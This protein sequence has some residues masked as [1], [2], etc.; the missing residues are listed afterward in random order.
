VPG[1]LEGVVVLDMSVAVTGP[2][3]AWLLGGMGARVIKL[4]GPQGDQSRVSTKSTSGM[5]PLFAMYNGGKESM[6]L[7]LKSERG[8]DVF[9]ELIPKVDVLLENLVGDTMADWGLDYDSL[10]KINPRLVYASISGF[11]RDSKYAKAPALDM[12]MQAMSGMMAATGFPEWPPTLG[13]VLFVD[14]LVSPHVAAGIVAA[15]YQRERTGHG[16]RLDV[17]M[18]DVA[19]C[20][21]FNLYNIFYNTGRVPQ[22]SGN[23]LVGY[24]PGNLYEASDG[25]VYIASN[26]DKQAYGAF[27]TIGREDL[28]TTEGF[29]TRGERWSNREEVDRIVEAWTRQRAKREVFDLM[30]ANDV[31]CGI[32]MDIEEVLNDDDLNARGVFVGIEQPGVGPLK[33]PRPPMIFGGE[34]ATVRPGRFLGEDNASLYRELLGYD[35]DAL[36]A[37]YEAGAA[38]P[39]APVEGEEARAG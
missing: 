39:P 13:G 16:Q 19:V 8:R 29:R 30:M 34:P 35:D 27:R 14:T 38:T 24:S 7:N 4:E 32:V 11:G 18:R 9:R 31:P 6:T 22:R 37:L 3:T 33:L 26:L 21:P 36:A 28:C 2:Y 20:I 23:L 25:Y 12:V 10:A 17:A 15:L 1:P 5:S